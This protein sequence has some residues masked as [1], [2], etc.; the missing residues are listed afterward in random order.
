MSRDIKFRGRSLTTGAWVYGSLVA[1]RSV[2]THPDIYEAE[3][4]QYIAVWAESV[5][6]STG[7]KDKNGVEICEGDVVKGIWTYGSKPSEEQLADP[8]EWD[9]RQVTF[10]RGYYSPMGTTGD[11]CFQLCEV[12]G[13]IYE[14]PELLET[15]S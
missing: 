2:K 13:N 8:D 10:E 5:G 3:T 7:L 1:Y 15:A 14:N 12:I 6:Q 9:V 4:N 11:A